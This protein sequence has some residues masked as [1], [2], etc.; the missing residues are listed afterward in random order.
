MP[1]HHTRRTNMKK[2]R[3]AERCA[4]LAKRFYHEAEA[5]TTEDW[6]LL[7]EYLAERDEDSLNALLTAY[8]IETYG[9]EE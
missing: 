4:T 7:F 6:E 8:G 5:P 1:P 3:L 2:P 9:T